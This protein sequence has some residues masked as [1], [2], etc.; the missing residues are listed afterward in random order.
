MSYTLGDCLLGRSRGL[1]A[2]PPIFLY[3]LVARTKGY[4]CDVG[5]WVL[6]IVQGPFS[7]AP[8]QTLFVVFQPQ[9]GSGGLGVCGCF[10]VG[11][12]TLR[13]GVRQDI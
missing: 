12:G 1:Y 8:R 6:S 5:V 2:T 4:T 9:T 7:V 11:W 13:V 3:T 10:C